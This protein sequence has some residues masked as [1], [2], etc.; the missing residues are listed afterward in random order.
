MIELNFVTYFV[1][2]I[3]CCLLLVLVENTVD[4]SNESKPANVESSVELKP[5]KVE[6]SVDVKPNILKTFVDVKPYLVGFV[7]VKPLVSFTNVKPSLVRSYF[8]KLHA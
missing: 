1:F 2:T 8:S 6:A 4:N 7:D 5:P 3:I